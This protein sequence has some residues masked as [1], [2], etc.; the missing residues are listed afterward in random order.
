MGRERQDQV[1]HEDPILRPGQEL[2]QLR[3]RQQVRTRFQAGQPHPGVA[4]LKGLED[5]RLGQ[6]TASAKGPKG[7]HRRQW[8]AACG[9]SGQALPNRSAPVGYQQALGRV[10]L[11]AIGVAQPLQ[12]GL[13]C[14][15][16]REISFR[17][18]AVVPGNTPDPPHPQWPFKSPLLRLGAQLV[19]D[20]HMVL[21]H[22]PVEVH[23]IEGAI[24]ADL[25]V[26]WPKPL[27]GRGE[28][29]PLCPLSVRVEH[30][31]ST[32][33][34][35]VSTKA[36]PRHGIGGRF[37]HEH[38]IGVFRPELIASVHRHAAGGGWLVEA[39]VLP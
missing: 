8:R 26:H 19:A 3:L 27:I 7:M 35:A 28:K 2:Q 24:G 15:C 32:D 23:D 39:A 22:A 10:A 14:G 18:P 38:V 37:R 5:D 29:L 6:F 31:L 12:Q 21:N 25:D 30:V 16:R 20:E 33:L 34:Q 11:P 36:Q 17:A 9:D 13:G 1:L 4:V